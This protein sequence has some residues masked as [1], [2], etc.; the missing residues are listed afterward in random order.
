MGQ[1]AADLYISGH[2]FKLS[3]L[4]WRVALYSVVV[5][6]L[7]ESDRISGGATE[8]NVGCFCCFGISVQV[9]LVIWICNYWHIIFDALK[10]KEIGVYKRSVPSSM[11][12]V[13]VTVEPEPPAFWPPGFGLSVP[14]RMKEVLKIARTS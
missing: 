5:Q 10:M 3:L 9:F 8:A 2:Y 13:A 4:Q 7:V 6:P 1:S 14:E 12:T 11:T